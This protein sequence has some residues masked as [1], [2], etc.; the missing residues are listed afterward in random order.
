MKYILLFLFV[1]SGSIASAQSGYWQQDLSYRI[2]ASLD[3]KLNSIKGDEEIIYKNNSPSTLEF[4]WFH[5][6]PNAYKNDQTALMQQIIHDTARSK[7]A[8]N[9][10]TGF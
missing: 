9:H 7:K 1:A 5:I 4:I 10:G 2:N 6:W 3:D 8:E